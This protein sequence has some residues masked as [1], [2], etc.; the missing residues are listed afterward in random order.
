MDGLRQRK[1]QKKIEKERK[2]ETELKISRSR[3]RK[4]VP[5][6]EGSETDMLGQ[7]DSAQALEATRWW[8]RSRW[9]LRASG[10]ERGPGR[11]V[12]IQGHGMHKG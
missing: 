5:V 6:C 12:H 11:L 7:A 8:Q 10:E 2:A 9:H 1:V 3:E 4:R